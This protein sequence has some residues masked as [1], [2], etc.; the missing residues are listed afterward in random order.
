LL[1]IDDDAEL[2]GVLAHEAGHVALDHA[3][4]RMVEAFGLQELAAIALG[5]NPVAVAQIG[6]SIAANGLLLVNSR[7]DETEADRFGARLASAANYDPQG[8][9]RFLGKLEKLESGHAPPVWLSD[10]PTSET[11]IRD[12]Q[13]YIAKNG[14]TGQVTNRA[15]LRSMKSR[16]TEAPEPR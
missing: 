7:Q 3:G 1:A 9:V 2:A 11:R 4:R 10:H 6:A 14:L 13:G 15:D 16:L 5:R 12:L 8:I